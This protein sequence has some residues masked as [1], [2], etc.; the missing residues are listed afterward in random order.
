MMKTKHFF[1]ILGGTPKRAHLF[2]K[3]QNG[4][5]GYLDPHTTY[6]ALEHYNDV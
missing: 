6:P 1:G 2:V 4:Y 3:H 5:L